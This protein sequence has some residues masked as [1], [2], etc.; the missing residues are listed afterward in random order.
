MQAADKSIEFLTTR[1]FAFVMVLGVLL[2][3]WL[4]PKSIVLF[5]M[6]GALA[7]A[8]VGAVLV[9]G[10]VHPVVPFALYFSV[11]FFADTR[12]PG[13]GISVNQPLAILFFLS[14]AV[15]KV[16]GNALKV[17]SRLLPLLALIS[18]YFTVNALTGLDFIRGWEHGRSVVVYFIMAW[19]VAGMLRTERS[20]VALAWLIVALTFASAIAGLME[21][22]QKGL[23][24][25]FSGR[26]AGQNRITGG[27]KNSI[28]FGWNLVFALPFVFFLFSQLRFTAGRVVAMTMGCVM[29]L[30]A[31]ITFNRQ[32]LIFI[33]VVAGA[34]AWLFRYRNRTL[35]MAFAVAGGVVVAATILP[36]LVKRFLSVREVKTDISYLERRDTFLVGKEMF[37]SAPVFGVGLGSF[38]VSWP[39]FIPPDYPTHAIQYQ[40]RTRLRFPDLG[41]WQLLSETGVVG[42]GCYLLLMGSIVGRAW[43]L[44]R[45]ALETDDLLAVNLAALVLTWS[46]FALLS[47]MIQ[48]NFL[49]VRNWVM[50]GV[51]LLMDERLLLRGPTPGQAPLEPV[52][53]PSEV[54]AEPDSV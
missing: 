51:A 3:M 47:A 27:A 39:D 9:A 11:L 7:V 1:R 30:A 6:T 2:V 32:T 48:D 15:W 22:A 19:C 29:V 16:R 31:L 28:V 5:G 26:F 17:E 53:V 38:P 52:G 40:E 14:F 36:L 21:A 13:V 46:L 54:M 44:R 8:A 42:L 34:C 23:L 12:L 49:Y 4:L 10:L 50:F 24:T 20:V 25:D 43:R 45:R 33:P 18:L 37:F 35:V 41:Y